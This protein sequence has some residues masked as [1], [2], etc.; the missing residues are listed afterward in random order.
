MRALPGCCTAGRR[1][2]C[3]PAADA[4]RCLPQLANRCQLRI[5]RAT[6]VATI[7]VPA[8]VLASAQPSCWPGSRHRDRRRGSSVG[9]RDPAVVPAVVIAIPPWFEASRSWPNHHRPARRHVVVMASREMSWLSGGQMPS[10]CGVPWDVKS[11]RT[12]RPRAIDA[13]LACSRRGFA[14]RQLAVS[15]ACSIRCC[16]LASRHRCSPSTE[17]TRRLS[18]Q[19]ADSTA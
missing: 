1:R 12:R 10:R 11:R 16:W 2:V 4:S 3:R 18:K 8:V 19:P 14:V 5:R 7:T 13:C 15:S 17:R 6:I 9:D